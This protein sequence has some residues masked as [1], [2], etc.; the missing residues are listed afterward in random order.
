[1]MINRSAYFFVVHGSRNFHYGQQLSL[2]VQNIKSQL[3]SQEISIPVATAYLELASQPLHQAIISFAKQCA[4]QGY[5]LI[6]VFPLFLLSG[7]HV[8]NDLPEQLA[9]A[10]AQSPLALELMP[11]LGRSDEL[12]SLLRSQFALHHSRERILLAHGTSLAKGNQELEKIARQLEARVAYWSMQPSLNSVINDLIFSQVES[13]AILPYF[14][15]TGKITKAIEN[16]IKILQ[17]NTEMKIITL[18]TLAQTSRFAEM[19]IQWM[20]LVENY[21][22]V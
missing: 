12:I 8:I 15:F 5:E 19:V 22:R 6:K 17:N 2:L 7:T 9:L 10:E 14:L 20:G 18:P 16:E 13:V 21:D 4:I 1:M 3:N 11:H